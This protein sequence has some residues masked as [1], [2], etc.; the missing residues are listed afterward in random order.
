[1]YLNETVTGSVFPPTSQRKICFI[2]SIAAKTD[3]CVRE[4]DQGL[5]ERK[6]EEGNW[7]VLER[8]SGCVC[9]GADS[10]RSVMTPGNMQEKGG[11]GPKEGGRGRD[12]KGNS[13]VCMCASS[14][15]WTDSFC[16]A[17]MY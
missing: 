9:V 7:M 3:L 8:D 1:M 11:Q 2:L 13:D 14:L 12:K 17:D 5:E 4:G 10:L 6:G 15:G 16:T